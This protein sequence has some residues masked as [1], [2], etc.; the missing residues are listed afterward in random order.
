MYVVVNIYKY[1]SFKYCMSKSILSG[2]MK[3]IPCSRKRNFTVPTAPS[4]LS[5]LVQLRDNT[6]TVLLHSVQTFNKY[7]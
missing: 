2:N 1:I 4:F 7:I 5:G 6:L 3:I